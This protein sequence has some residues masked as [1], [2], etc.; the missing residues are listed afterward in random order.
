[1]PHPR[2]SAPEPHCH[3]GCGGP[4]GLGLVVIVVGGRRRCGTGFRDGWLS[5]R[6]RRIDLLRLGIGSAALA[7]A[8][9]SGTRLALTALRRRSRRNCL[10]LLGHLAIDQRL[11][12]GGIEAGA[13]ALRVAAPGLGELHHYTFVA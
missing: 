8:A 10:D 7:F 12:L 13:F 1:R 11:G 5:G 9:T 6:R 4:L 2:R 3:T